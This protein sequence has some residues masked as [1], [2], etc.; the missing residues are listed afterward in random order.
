MDCE[1]L[2]QTCADCFDARLSGDGL[3]RFLDAA[4]GTTIYASCCGEEVTK[5][6]D[7]GKVGNPRYIHAEVDESLSPEVKTEAGPSGSS[8][9]E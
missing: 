5:R 3:Q 8:E 1:Q 9:A 2:G 4:G 7:A 6:N